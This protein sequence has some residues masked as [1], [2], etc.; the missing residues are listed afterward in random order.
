MKKAL[1]IILLSPIL[2][3]AQKSKAYFNI[4]AEALNLSN[5]DVS[6]GGSFAIGGKGKYVDAGVGVMLAQFKGANDPYI[7]AFLDISIH[8][9][10][11]IARP[12]ID[13]QGGWGFYRDQVA[14]AFYE[15]GGLFLRPGG[16]IW[17]PLKKSAVFLRAFYAHSAFQLVDGQGR[18]YSSSSESGW[19]A[20]IGVSL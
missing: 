2:S 3:F 6:F 9:N 17:L 4:S 18:E 5:H 7:P 13:L 15:K 8:S 10:R 20:S 16:G 11:R 1:F 19:S 14:G 12:F